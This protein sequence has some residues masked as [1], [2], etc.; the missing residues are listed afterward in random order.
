MVDGCA[1][2]LGRRLPAI[3]VADRHDDRGAVVGEGTRR[4]L[5]EPGRRAGDDGEPAREIDAGQDVVGRG[6]EPE[7]GHR[8][9]LSSWRA[10]SSGRFV[11]DLVERSAKALTKPGRPRFDSP[12]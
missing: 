2:A 12:R 10:P 5:P 1:D 11:S 4:L 8:A 3:D 7:G 9:I 6:G